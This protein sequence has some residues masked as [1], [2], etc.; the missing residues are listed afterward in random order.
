MCGFLDEELGKMIKVV[1]KD[2]VDVNFKFRL[3]GSK[4][5][6]LIVRRVCGMDFFKRNSLSR[7]S[8]FD[9]II[10][11]N[12]FSRKDKLKS[13]ILREEFRLLLVFFERRDS[14]EKCN[15]LR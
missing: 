11:F 2:V 3:N 7:S 9:D 10:I 8:E 15:Y 5:S 4:W 14:N 1:V 6:F 12:F 13:F